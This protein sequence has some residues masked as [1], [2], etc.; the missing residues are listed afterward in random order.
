MNITAIRPNIQNRTMFRV[1]FRPH[2]NR[3]VI[4]VRDFWTMDMIPGFAAEV[5]AKI[6]EARAVS[7]DFDVLVES[8]D[9]PVQANDVAD[10]LP[11]IMRGGMALT[12]GRSAVIVGSQ[13]SKLQ[14]ERTLTHSR[15]K[16]FLAR[17]EAE[18]WLAAAPVLA[19]A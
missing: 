17:A 4:H 16:V 8:L 18:A 10:L 2:T 14:A 19:D 7:G 1:D 9:F 15:V 13:L 5:G 11:S 3:I 6:Q 12:S